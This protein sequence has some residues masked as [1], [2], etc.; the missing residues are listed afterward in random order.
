MHVK[1]KVLNPAPGTLAK[2]VFAWRN[3]SS[4]GDHQGP[5]I[6]NLKVTVA[7]ATGDE[8]TCGSAFTDA[9]DGIEYNTVQIGSQC[10]MKENLRT[11]KD[12]DGSDLDENDFRYPDFDLDNLQT[13]GLLYS[14][15][16]MM[17][18][19]QSSTANPSGVQGICPEG[20]HVPSLAEWNKLIDTTNAL[21]PNCAAKA[22]AENLTVD[23]TY[24]WMSSSDLCTPGYDQS[25]NNATGF[26]ARPAGFYGSEMQ[27]NNFH[28]TAEFWS[29][30]QDESDDYSAYYIEIYYSSTDAHGIP[31]SK[32]HYRSVRCVRA[33]G[34]SGTVSDNTCPGTPT[35][36]DE[37][38]NTYSTVL[39]GN[40]CWMAENLRSTRRGEYTVQ[41]AYTPGYEA[42]NVPTYGYLYTWNDAMAG[43]AGSDNNPSGV[44][45]LCPD[46]WHIPS[47]DEW[48]D[49]LSFLNTNTQ[50]HCNG[51]NQATAKA[52]S[53]T[54]G[55]A[56]NSGDCTV[57]NDLSANNA[58]GFSAYPAGR[59]SAQ[60]GVVNFSYS[61]NF[62]GSSDYQD[63]AF[64]IGWY[65]DSS[66][67]GNGYYSSK[68]SGS[69]VRCVKN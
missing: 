13:Y 14:W 66:S 34:G 45:G 69:S 37:E 61:T 19:G 10:W 38:N 9:R 18:G 28:E 1:E 33:A 26:S 43:Q 56:G 52:L 47:S 21:Y 31:F 7:E 4:V 20:W 48:D 35:V 30:T 27:F 17:N 11:M 65:E 63:D 68:T 6:T 57:G 44:Q 15:N 54:S 42:T 40:Q 64:T 41:N 36:T 29:A 23:D 59:Y 25:N 2:L 24:L 46:G 60:Y 5:I 12:P 51:I 39:I 49:L 16:A 58:T 62:W 3:D 32:N 22:L 50:Y 67:L 55:W 8:F 53:S